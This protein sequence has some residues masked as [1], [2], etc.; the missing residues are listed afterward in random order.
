MAI[1]YHIIQE[2]SLLRCLT[3]DCDT[4]IHCPEIC[5][6]WMMLGNPCYKGM[7]SVVTP[8]TSPRRGLIYTS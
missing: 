5:N 6:L 1:Q 7:S 3:R 2:R 8:I 4:D